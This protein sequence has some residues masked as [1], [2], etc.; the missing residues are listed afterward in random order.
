MSAPAGGGGLVARSDRKLRPRLS[1]IVAYFAVT[2]GLFLLPFGL[3]GLDLAL[4]PAPFAVEPDALPSGGSSIQRFPDGSTVTVLVRPSSEAAKAA[5]EENVRAAPHRSFSQSNGKVA[6][7]RY[8]NVA[9]G[10]AWAWLRIDHVVVG[11]EAADRAAVDQRLANLTVVTKNPGADPLF[12]FV[13]L[14]EHN[15]GVVIAAIGIYLLVIAFFMVKGAAW[16]ARIDPAPGTPA[17]SADEL[18]SRLLR[19]NELALPWRLEVVRPG[20][21]RAEWVYVDARWVQAQGAGRL[22]TS[23]RLTLHVD[24]SGRRVSVVESIRSRSLGAGLGGFFANFSYWRG[25][26]FYAYEAGAAVGLGFR[27]GR[28]QLA[29]A[30]RYRFSATEM[31]NPLVEAIVDGGWTYAPTLIGRS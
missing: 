11:V 26:T 6:L 19:V 4:A 27:D 15:P 20:V 18:R 24:E 29:E 3:V 30:Y 23:R 8:E 25:I 7:T 9:T 17:V 31:R 16:A 21:F 14:C 10:K 12:E 1:R 5:V 22:R 13:A 28:W 2:F